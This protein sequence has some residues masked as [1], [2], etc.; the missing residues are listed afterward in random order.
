MECLRDQINVALVG[1][2]RWVIE[3][4]AQNFAGFLGGFY[5]GFEIIFFHGKI[6]QRSACAVRLRTPARSPL[7]HQRRNK[8][9]V[10][11]RALLKPLFFG[12]ISSASEL[13]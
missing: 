7:Y 11:T 8:S 2:L 4:F 12:A 10:T 6:T 13:K 5:S 1:N 3:L 9:R